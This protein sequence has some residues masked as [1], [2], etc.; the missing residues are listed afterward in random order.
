MK[1]WRLKSKEER[2]FKQGHPWV[3]S[4]ELQESP[5]GV[6]L[7]EWVELRDAGGAFLAF[8]F[9]NPHSLIAFRTLS[10]K[11]LFDSKEV[12][13]HK[14]DAHIQKLLDQALTHRLDWFQPDQ[15]FRWIYGEVDS[16]PGLVVDRFVGQQQTVYVVQPNS[17][18][19][20][21]RVD[22]LVQGIL[23]VHSK[24]FEKSKAVIV[25]RRDSGSRERE[26]LDKMPTVMV[27]EISDVSAYQS[28]EFKVPAVSGDGSILMK[29]DLIGGQ[30]TG[31]FF[32]QLE[33]VRWVAQ[34]LN[35]K[36]SRTHDLKILDLCSYV[37][38]WSTQ[39]VNSILQ[40]RPT[41]QIEVTCVDAS[42]AALTFA[43]SNIQANSGSAFQHG[44]LRIKRMKTDVFEPMPS[45]PHQSYDVVIADPP[46]LIKSRKV[47]PQGK[48]AYGQLMEQAILRTKMGGL[49]VCCSCSQ[50]LSDQDFIELLGKAARRSNRTVRWLASGTPSLDHPARFDFQEGAYLKVWIGQVSEQ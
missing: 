28:F 33:N 16:L 34:L 26:G 39:L 36:R 17:S 9:G 47:I 11:P 42:D 49:V 8:G 10:R 31:Y 2:R 4:N 25:L 29:A 38:Q 45:I 1:T 15:S 23:A 22:R 27:P 21:L 24:R 6:Q 5:K 7:G 19:M 37:G 30:K 41:T 20:N 3:Y 48:Q 50:L 12:D 32:D 43:E 14:V 46:A 44:S 35:R 13:E 18:G 40:T